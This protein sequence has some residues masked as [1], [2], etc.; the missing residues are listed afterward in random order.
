MWGCSNYFPFTLFGG[1][2][3]GGFGFPFP[4]LLLLVVLVLAAVWI[5]RALRSDPGHRC[6]AQADR[7]DALRIL[8]TRLAE[9]SISEEEY[10]R[11]RRAV[12]S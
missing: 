5:F 7:D 12:E 11:L 1:R 6:S 2:F 3:G 4:G 10:E 8:R 9:G